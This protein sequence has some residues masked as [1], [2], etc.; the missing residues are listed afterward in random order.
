M[1]LGHEFDLVVLVHLWQV[2]TVLGQGCTGRV[3]PEREMLFAAA[4]KV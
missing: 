3:P 1:A 2:V 4:S